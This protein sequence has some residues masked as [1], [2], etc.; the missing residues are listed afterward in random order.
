[1]CRIRRSAWRDRLSI[2]RNGVIVRETRSENASTFND[3][4]TIEGACRL[5][6][7]IPPPPSSRF[8]LV[9]TVAHDLGLRFRLGGRGLPGSP[10]LVFPAHTLALFV[11]DCTAYG[12]DCLPAQ[13]ARSGCYFSRQR[14]LH[15]SDLSTYQDVLSHRG[16]RSHVVF[17]CATIDRASLEDELRSLTTG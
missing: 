11:C 13:V 2:W 8:R 16:W 9:R 1:M 7:A 12:H 15:Q 14:R 3:K 17:D 4:K 10:H 5:R 6:K